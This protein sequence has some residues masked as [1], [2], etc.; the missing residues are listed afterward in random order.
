MVDQ[1]APVG[2]SRQI[3]LDTPVWPRPTNEAA[4]SLDTTGRVTH[5][6]MTDEY[7]EV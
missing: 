7:R 1:P 6:E 4:A 2:T 5:Q 3:T